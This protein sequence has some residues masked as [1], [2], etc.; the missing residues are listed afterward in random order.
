[1]L[2]FV[3]I[4]FGLSWIVIAFFAL[5]FV[6]RRFFHEPRRAAAF[7]ASVV[8]A[9]LVGMA[10]PFSGL[11]G[12]SLPA[13]PTG[14]PAR[15]LAAHDVTAPCE[16]AHFSGAVKALGNIDAFGAL[17]DGKPVP[18]PSGFVAGRGVTLWLNGW[19]ADVPG[20]VPA[21]AACI[22][23]DGK[24]QPGASAQYGNPRPDVAT[25]YKVD[26]LTSTGFTV[27]IPVSAL[28]RGLHHVTVA[29]V[30]PSGETDALPSSWTV[31][32]H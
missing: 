31:S 17:Q 7:A 29:V 6:G 23:I 19:A 1:V 9:F 18:A 22:V 24:L 5:R 12:G 15:Y 4:F 10:W 21:Q 28:H 30:L 8:V 27:T 26:A 2:L 3:T 16:S 20:K 13:A 25:A 14:A 32:V 11:R